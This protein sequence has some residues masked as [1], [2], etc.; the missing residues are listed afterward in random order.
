MI[1][2]TI[3]IIIALLLAGGYIWCQRN[4]GLQNKFD[5]LDNILNKTKPSEKDIKKNFLNLDEVE[6]LRELEEYTT[7]S[8][9]EIGYIRSVYVEKGIKYIEIDYIQWLQGD[10]ALQA[11]REDGECNG[12]T[13]CFVPNDYYIRNQ[14]TTTVTLKLSQKTSFTM[15]TYKILERGNMTADEKI[16]Y[17]NFA[18]IFADSEESSTKFAP[19]HLTIK[20]DVVTEVLE[21]YVP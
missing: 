11:M 1:I 5:F 21:Q 19:Y 18:S 8:T 20:N 9:N 17:T 12:T 15:Q 6:E 2:F 4:Q 10:E 13:E 14:D 3:I 16:S 7:E